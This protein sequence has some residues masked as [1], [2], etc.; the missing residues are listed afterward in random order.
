MPNVIGN[1]SDEQV[2]RETVQS[3][4]QSEQ[5]NSQAT[6]S[7]HDSRALYNPQL[8]KLIELANDA[9]LSREVSLENMAFTPASPAD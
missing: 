5:I 1:Q 3:Q 2:E 6:S 8:E 4:H 7:P 9:A